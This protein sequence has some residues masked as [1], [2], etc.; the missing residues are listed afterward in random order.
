MAKKLGLE[1]ARAVVEAIL[2][3]RRIGVST[4]PPPSLIAVAS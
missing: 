3:A 4:L 1:E 2:K